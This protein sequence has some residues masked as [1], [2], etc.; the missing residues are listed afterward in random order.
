MKL[1]LLNAATHPLALKHRASAAEGYDDDDDELCGAIKAIL[2]RT[3]D[4]TSRSENV[5]RQE[6]RSIVVFVRLT[7][8]EHILS[9][10]GQ[11]LLFEWIVYFQ[12]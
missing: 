5:L 12:F 8:T 9:C 2:D 6:V 11:E 7:I 1:Q 10:T 3:I 4:L